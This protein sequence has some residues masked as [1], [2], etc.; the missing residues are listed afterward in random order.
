LTKLL[1]LFAVVTAIHCCIAP[2][3]ASSRQW[4]PTPEAL[5]RDYATINDVKANGDLTLLL[6]FV[7]QMV[8]SGTAGADIVADMARKNVVLMVV[9]GHID[10]T[11]GTLSFDDLQSLDARDQ[12]GKALTAI[13]RDKL[14]P[15]NVAIVSS[16]EAMLRQ[17]MG[18][19]GKG[20]KMFVFDSTGLDSC[21]RGRLQVLLGGETYT[22]DT[23]FP[24]CAQSN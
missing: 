20:M 9:R 4:K 11:T 6:W 10:K 5:A 15:T 1:K 14:P 8:P 21:G 24:T 3:P 13:V 18:A 16:M 12:D 22:W 23:P 17:S 7:P 2:N 19:M